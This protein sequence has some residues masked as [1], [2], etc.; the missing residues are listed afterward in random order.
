M[1]KNNSA[2]VPLL[3]RFTLV[4]FHLLCSLQ[5][6]MYL[7]RQGKKLT[8]YRPTRLHLSFPTLPFLP[9]PPLSLPHYTSP[10]HLG[11]RWMT[12]PGPP[13]ATSPAYMPTLTVRPLLGPFPLDNPLL[14][15]VIQ[16]SPVYPNLNPTVSRRT[17]TQELPLD[18]SRLSCSGL[19]LLDQIQN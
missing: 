3:P 9:P 17:A 10:L 13:L 1:L 5:Q 14:L 4:L 18:T 11:H 7:P 8:P 16:I 2:C 12:N 6:M 15:W 19:L